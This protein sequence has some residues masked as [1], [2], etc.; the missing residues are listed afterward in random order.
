MEHQ[1]H[2]LFLTEREIAQKVGVCQKT[3]GYW[4]DKYDLR[5]PNQD[6]RGIQLAKSWQIPTS[7]ISLF[8]KEYKQCIANNINS[9]V[10]GLFEGHLLGDADIQ[11]R[12]NL[13]SLK[14]KYPEYLEYVSNQLRREKMI[15]KPISINNKEGKV[16][17]HNKE[18]IQPSIYALNTIA[19]RDIEHFHRR[20]YRPATEE[21]YEQGLSEKRRFVKI[22]PTDIV[23]TKDVLLYWFIDD[24]Y[25]TFRNNGRLG[26]AI[27]LST[28][29]FDIN[30]INKLRE[31]L[32]LL[33]IE[34]IITGDGRILITKKEPIEI[35]YNLIGDC[36]PEIYNIYGYKW[37]K[38]EEG[39]TKK[40]W[41]EKKFGKSLPK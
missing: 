25:I 21:D 15:T 33:G 4:L 19:H 40:E 39:L 41:F 20:W 14:S 11:F 2:D 22:I 13:F 36:P 31:K 18:Y 34:N 5:I 29:G 1:T 27:G 3:I 26:G 38:R 24:G 16:I 6:S 28:M 35:F 7:G 30:N 12:H 37:R 8:V 32:I 9:T 17:I 23:L 10:S